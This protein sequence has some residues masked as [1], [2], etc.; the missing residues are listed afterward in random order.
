MEIRIIPIFD[1]DKKVNWYEWVKC[2]IYDFA[3]CSLVCYAYLPACLL[4]ERGRIGKE[5]LIGDRLKYYMDFDN[6]KVDGKKIDDLDSSDFD[7]KICKFARFLYYERTEKNDYGQDVDRT[8][9]VIKADFKKFIGNLGYKDTPDS[10]AKKI[11]IRKSLFKTFI[12]FQGASYSC[13]K[14]E[15]CNEMTIFDFNNYDS[16]KL[17]D[18]DRFRY[19]DKLLFDNDREN[20]SFIDFYGAEYGFN[21]ELL[22]KFYSILIVNFIRTDDELIMYMKMIDTIRKELDQ[23]RYSAKISLENLEK[24]VKSDKKYQNNEYTM[25]EV[26][27]YLW[28]LKNIREEDEKNINTINNILER[29]PM[30]VKIVLHFFSLNEIK[31]R[32]FIKLILE[33]ESPKRKADISL[34]E[35]VELWNII[36][37]CGKNSDFYNKRLGEWVKSLDKKSKNFIIEFILGKEKNN[38]NSDFYDQLN[39]WDGK[40]KQ[41]ALFMN[42]GSEQT[43]TSWYIYINIL[44]ARIILPILTSRNNS[45]LETGLKLFNAK[46]HNAVNDKKMYDI[47]NKRMDK[48]SIFNIFSDAFKYMPDADEASVKEIQEKLNRNEKVNQEDVINAFNNNTNGFKYNVFLF[49]FRIILIGNSYYYQRYDSKEGVT[50]DMLKAHV[51]DNRLLS[52][53]KLNMG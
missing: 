41:V 4:Y 13:S 3:K 48:K 33:N 15:S 18:S 28:R 53:L 2:I 27:S 25:Y 52:L 47:L 43:G 38:S 40:I 21:E 12:L 10:E 6:L 49:V 31:R 32:N 11:E 7:K 19:L 14:K 34:E 29:A 5:Q 45:K 44:T 35:R 20:C 9:K 50:L 16:E 30:N 1:N 17:Y 42:I 51:S 37:H 46:Q 24:I 36:E 26:E 23:N 39:N 8:Y 22:K